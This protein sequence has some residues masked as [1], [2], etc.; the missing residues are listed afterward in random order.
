M[1]EIIEKEIPKAE[2]NEI[3]MASKG[4]FGITDIKNQLDQMNKL[5]FTVVIAVVVAVIAVLI[6]V[7]GV[8]LD[9][10]RYN[11]AAYKEYS[12]KIQTLDMLQKSNKVL[13]QEVKNNQTIV[14]DLLRQKDLDDK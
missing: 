1:S 10:M 5:F 8:F 6:S 2:E 3:A 13:L 9:Q 7:I 14:I 4:S 11:N 12:G